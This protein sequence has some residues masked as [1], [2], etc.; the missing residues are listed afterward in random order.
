MTTI[1]FDTQELVNE[2]KNNGF[3]LEQSEAVIT[4]IKKAQHELATKKDLHDL[5]TG[6]RNEIRVLGK[7]LTIRIGGIIFVAFGLFSG[8]LAYIVK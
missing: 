3:T 7:D 1:T 2:L 5:E 8:L 6:L 4:V